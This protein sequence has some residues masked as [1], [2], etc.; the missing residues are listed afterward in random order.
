MGWGGVGEP[1]LLNLATPLLT[2]AVPFLPLNQSTDYH[3]TI[4]NTNTEIRNV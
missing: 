1:P 3:N 4:L 2:E